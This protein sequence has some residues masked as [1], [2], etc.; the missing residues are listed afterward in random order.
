VEAEHPDMSEGARENYDDDI[1]MH[2]KLNIYFIKTIEISTDPL[3]L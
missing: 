2:P 3:I 1:I